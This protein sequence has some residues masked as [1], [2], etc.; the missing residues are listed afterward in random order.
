[1]DGDPNQFCLNIAK[2]GDLPFEVCSLM[3]APRQSQDKEHII[4]D[5][6]ANPDQSE[7]EEFSKGSDLV[8]L[9][10]TPDSMAIEAVLNAVESLSTLE[11]YGVVLTMVDSRQKA[12]E[13]Q[14]RRAIASV[15]IPVFNQRIR[16]FVA[17]QKAALE[18]VPVNQV[19][20]DY[21]RIAWGEYVALGEEILSHA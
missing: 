6:A 9:P 14:A 10:C 12:T 16:R 8:I 7:I 15:G 11:H 19:R 18:G 2:R 13:E 21:A 17:Y 3:A 1:M 20:D 5:T 4:I